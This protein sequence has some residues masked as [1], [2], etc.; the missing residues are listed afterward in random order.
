MATYGIQTYL[1]RGVE[2]FKLVLGLPWYGLLYEYILGVP[3]F[4]GQIRYA[5][6]LDFLRFNFF[7]VLRATFANRHHLVR[8][9]K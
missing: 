2:P 6:V 7:D 3:F 5:E 1:S 4:N 9:K 8:H